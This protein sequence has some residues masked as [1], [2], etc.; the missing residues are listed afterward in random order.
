MNSGEHSEEPPYRRLIQACTLIV[1]PNKLA[2]ECVCDKCK[3]APLWLGVSGLS[4]GWAAFI[5]T[6][7][8][9]ISDTHVH[10]HQET[11]YA[12]KR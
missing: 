5:P 8:L 4:R 10:Q 11:A 2:S 9:I 3:P 1:V 6:A 12:M 7:T